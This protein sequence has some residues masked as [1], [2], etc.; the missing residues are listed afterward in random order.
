[1]V[2]A[3]TTE[4]RM[5]HYWVEKHLGRPMKCSHCGTTKSRYYDWANISHEYKR[6]LSDWV[7]LCKSCHRLFDRPDT[8][9]QGHKWTPENSYIRPD[10]QRD[11]RTC[12]R[13]SLR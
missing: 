7:R 2:K 11:C 5:L 10:G 12:K 3:G 8:C 9:K 6:E 13:E 4:Y 1:M